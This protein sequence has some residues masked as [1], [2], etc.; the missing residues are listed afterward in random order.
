MTK[1]IEAAVNDLLILSD[2]DCFPAS[3]FWIQEMLTEISGKKDIVL[4]FSPY[5]CTNKGL[6]NNFIRFEA[7]YTAIQYLSFALLG[8]PY[9]GVGRNLLYRKSIFIEKGAFSKH[10]NIASGDDDLFINE[11][12]S[13]TNTSINVS[14][15]AFIYSIP[16]SSWRGYY[17]QKTR[18][19]T[20]GIKYKLKHQVM[21][22]MLALSHFGHYF[23]AMFLLFDPVLVSSAILLILVRFGIVAWLYWRILKLLQQTDLWVWS[24]L[25]DAALNLYYI[26]FSPNILIGNKRKWKQ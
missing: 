8:Q 20:T 1:G 7:I 23:F 10:M 12:A 26:A 19:L 25:F 3:K 16:K 13:W 5:I 4:G 2:A 14:P 6:L 22:G 15:D 9:M 24:L 18:H 17:H 21:L 11:A